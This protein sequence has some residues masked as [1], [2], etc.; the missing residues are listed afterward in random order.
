[1]SIENTL[2]GLAKRAR[3]AKPAPWARTRATK[4]RPDR[5]T[6][7][8][9]KTNIVIADLI[10]WSVEHGDDPFLELVDEFGEAA[11]D[12]MLRQADSHERR[13]PEA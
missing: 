6:E 3:T 2:A 7:L 5:R 8:R 12:E 13:G 11:R 10:R 9:R 4:S 1:M